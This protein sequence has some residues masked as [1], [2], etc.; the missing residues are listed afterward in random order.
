MDLQVE[1]LW[2]KYMERQPLHSRGPKQHRPARQGH[3]KYII[4]NLYET[5]ENNEVLLMSRGDY[6]K[7]SLLW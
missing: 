6:L 2:G 4:A 5:E 7:S 1:A 3:Y